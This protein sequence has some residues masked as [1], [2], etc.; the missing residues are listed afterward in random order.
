MTAADFA[1]WTLEREGAVL[2]PGAALPVLP[3]LEAAIAGLPSDLAGIRIRG[4]PA[5]PEL[6]VAG[7]I[8]E[9]ARDLLGDEAR[10]VRAI[11]FDKSD[12]ANWALTW[13][14]DRTITVRERVAVAGFGP[15]TVKQGILHV[16]PPF[17][18]LAAMVT[19]RVHLDPVPMDNAPLCIAPG[20]H[21]LGLVADRDA[22]RAA[23]QSGVAACLAEAG[24]IW[25]YATPILH[26][27]ARAE[28]GQRRRVLQI[29]YA[30]T[31]LPGGLE[32]S[33]I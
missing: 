14:Q 17:W 32:W 24:D 3:A 28:A 33:G 29:D 27:S 16:A 22:E 26:A 6:L 18:L 1:T 19:L 15:W 7:P 10:P 5:I 31:A 25:G 4:L 12:A 23:L 13:H 21:R 2:R 9:V 30:A 20:S 8:V 11:L